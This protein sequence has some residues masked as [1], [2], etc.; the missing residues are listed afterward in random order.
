M[1][2]HGQATDTRERKRSNVA[3]VLVPAERFESARSFEPVL[4]MS[5]HW[6]ETMYKQP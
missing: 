1:I 2:P 6:R 5:R 4:V 3:Y